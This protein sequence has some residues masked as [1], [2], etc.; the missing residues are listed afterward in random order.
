MFCRFSHTHLKTALGRPVCVTIPAPASPGNHPVLKPGCFGGECGPPG[1]PT[2]ICLSSRLRLRTGWV[3]Y[4][5]MPVCAGG[6]M[7]DTMVQMFG[8]LAWPLGKAMQLIYSL[9]Q[10]YGFTIIIFTILIR[11]LM[12]PLTLKQQKSQARMAAFQ[13]MIQELQKKWANDKQRQQQEVMK[14]QEENNLKMTGGCLPMIVNMIVLFGIIAV[15]QAPMQYMLD[16]PT[17]EVSKA[18]AIVQVHQPDVDLAS[19]TY[20]MESILIGNIKSNPEWFTEGTAVPNDVLEAIEN[21]NAAA[22]AAASAASGSEAAASATSGSEAAG[23]TSAST[24]GA[25]APEEGESAA[26]EGTTVI[27][28]DPGKD[29]QPGTVE[30][31]LNFRFEFLGLNLADRPSFSDFASLIL[32]I[33]SILTMFLSQIIVMRTSGQTQ[34]QGS[35][36]IMTIAMGAFFGWFA[37][38]IP[39]GFSLYYT[40]S[41]VV[42]TVQ[43][44]IVR[45]IHDPEEEREKILQEIEER[46]KA[47][48]AKK[49]IVVQD[50]SGRTVE[51]ELS[52]SEI[53]RIRLAKARELDAQKYA[54]EE[55]EREKQQEV[56]DKARA[57]DAEKYE[58]AATGAGDETKPEEA[59][60]VQAEGEENAA[61]E[62]ELEIEKE[63]QAEELVEASD[64]LEKNTAREYKPGRRKRARKNKGQTQPGVQDDAGQDAEK[65][66]E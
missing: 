21:P 65:G 33:L 43:Q 19:N 17:T 57:K 9:I 47:K 18:A 46:K 39:A 52:D 60:I 49:K 36:W 48:K 54:E 10:N 26:P 55:A 8:I 64:N 30:K 38:T 61:E 4:K 58:G 66:E 24:S 29:G 37:F 62:A 59:A 7:D 50:E 14:F 44:L 45:R 41:N 1:A 23:S 11:L 32:P 63:E 15:I 20:T 22:S 6:R 2:S 12:F 27:T 34:S 3:Q 5:Y 40:A 53:A 28:L 42:M 51:K 35:M 25:A 13:P 56:M 16:V 31:V